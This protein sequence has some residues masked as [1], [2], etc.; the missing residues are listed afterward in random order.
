MAANRISTLS[1]SVAHVRAQLAVASRM[2]WKCLATGGQSY[3]RQLS[4]RQFRRRRRL[5]PAT[6]LARWTQH[7]DLQFPISAAVGFVG[8]EVEIVPLKNP[9]PDRGI[10]DLR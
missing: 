5:R 8:A 1:Y 4:A 10:W 3:R 9:Q 2:Y 7:W 6:A